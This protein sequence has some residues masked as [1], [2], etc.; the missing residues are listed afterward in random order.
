M[1]KKKTIEK[2][3]QLIRAKLLIKVQDQIASQVK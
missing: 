3:G 2:E 1:W